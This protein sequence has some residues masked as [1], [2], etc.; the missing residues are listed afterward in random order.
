MSASAGRVL[1]IPKG[2]YDSSVTYNML[3]MVYYSGKSYICKQ[4]STGNDPTNTVYWQ[5]M[6]DGASTFD[7]L[8]D[9]QINNVQ[10]GDGIYWDATAQKWKN[11]TP[12]SIAITSP[13]TTVDYVAGE[14]LDLTGMVVTAYYTGGSSKDITNECTFSPANGAILS[15]ADTSVTVTWRTF[16]ATQ[17]I[18]VQVFTYGVE[19]DGSSSPVFTRT[20]NSADFVDPVPQMSDGNGGWTT[21][22][23]PFDNIMPW[24]GMERVNDPDAGVLVSIPKFYYKLS[25][26]LQGGVKIQ[27]SPTPQTGF[28]VSPAHMDRGDGNG[29]RDVIYVGA[30][31]CA[32]D[33][34]KSKTGALPARDITSYGQYRPQVGTDIWVM[35]MTVWITI[36]MLYLVEFATWDSQSA[37][38]YGCGNSSSTTGEASGSCDNMTYH[39][40][41]NVSNRTTYGTT[42]YRYIEDLWGNWWDIIAGIYYK[43]SKWYIRIDPSDNDSEN[44]T[45]VGI[46]PLLWTDKEIKGYVA[47]SVSGYEWLFLPQNYESNSNYDTYV[48]DKIN[49]SLNQSFFVFVGGRT[50][51]REKGYGLFYLGAGNGAQSGRLMKLPSA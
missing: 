38:G 33:D 28:S 20:D 50:R 37:I 29:E 51:D 18:T 23:S 9:V 16:S 3:D 49:C 1:I 12:T 43:D 19:W 4:T 32:S 5:I 41:T 40:G 15:S 31:H 34:Y 8:T 27:I 35:D 26:S 7:A 39:T 13:P 46:A 22:S 30:Y 48:C 45:D 2:D 24:A 36:Q 21:G 44:G 14:T 11:T 25:A 42:R 17:E 47:S 6:A 10:D